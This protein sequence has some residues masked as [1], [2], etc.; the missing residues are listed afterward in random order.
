[1]NIQPSIN[2]P[3][4]RVYF[5]DD[6]LPSKPGMGALEKAETGVGTSRDDWSTAGLT[7][8]GREWFRESAGRATTCSLKRRAS[9]FSAAKASALLGISS[10][11][12]KM[13]MEF[14]SICLIN[15]FLFV[16]NNSGLSGKCF[17]F[18]FERAR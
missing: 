15:L 13:A 5:T 4:R 9:I 2:Y 12:T 11:L 3:F 10:L 1:M 7:E 17:M 14:G 6:C 18:N 16:M 8:E